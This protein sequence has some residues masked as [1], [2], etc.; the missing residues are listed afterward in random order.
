MRLPR[1]SAPVVLGG[2]LFLL[3]ALGGGLAVVL[4]GGPSRPTAS[5][6]QEQPSETPTSEPTPTETAVVLEPTATPSAT[7]SPTVSATAGPIATASALPVVTHRPSPTPTCGSREDPCPGV[8]EGVTVAIDGPLTVVQGQ[9]YTYTLHVSWTK[10]RPSHVELNF[11]T[12]ALPRNDGCLRPTA[13]PAGSGPGSTT[14]VI[15]HVWEQS[16]EGQFVVGKAFTG[17]QYYEGGDARQYEVH[18][19]PAPTPQPS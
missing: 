10:E 17:C 8:P 14:V 11:N 18:V 16:R 4:T 3:A 13:P 15:K 5:L 2:G 6:Q 19:S 1:L 7:P 9:E 12:Y